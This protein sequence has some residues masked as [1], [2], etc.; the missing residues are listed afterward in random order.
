M[1]RCRYHP[2]LICYSRWCWTECSKFPKDQLTILETIYGKEVKRYM[3]KQWSEIASDKTGDFSLPRL[4]DLLNTEFEITGV[5]FG[6]GKYGAYAVAKVKGKGEYRT[7]SEVLLDQ[8]KEI[9]E[10]IRDNKDSVIVKLQ[11]VKNYYTF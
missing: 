2:N 11:K 3:P 5:R 1:A 7:S 10:Y 8:L 9:A 6:E 4:S